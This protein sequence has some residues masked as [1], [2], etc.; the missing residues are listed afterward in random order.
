MSE[1]NDPTTDP[2]TDPAAAQATKP[3]ETDWQAEAKKWEARSKDNLAKLREAEPKLTEYDRLVEASK[4]DLE[5]AQSEVT[6]WQSEAER[7]RGSSVASRIEVLASGEFAD[8]TD[9]ASALT[10]DPA[11]YLG[12]DGVINDAA[13]KADLADVLARKPHWRKSEV[14]A[15]PR[16]PAPNRAQGASGNAVADPAA[17]FASILQGQ[18]GSR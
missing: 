1:N 14:Q 5:R 6:R 4:T 7:W 12:V 8:P 16:A 11:K 10:A 17:A 15:S 13:I 9:A 3:A 2:T 18:M